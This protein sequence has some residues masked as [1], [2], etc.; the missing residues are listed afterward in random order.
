MKQSFWKKL[1][2]GVIIGISAGLLVWLLSEVVFKTFFFRIE[3]QTYDWRMRRAVT[4]PENPIDEIVIVDVDERSV[5][6]L[7]SYY[8]WPRERWT[9]LINFL[10][11]AGVSMIGLDF[12]FDPDLRHTPEENKFQQAM[13]NAEMVC[14]ALYLSQAD[15]D[16][17]RPVMAREPS[18][19]EYQRFIYQVPKSLYEILIPEERIEPEDANFLNAGLTAGYVNLFPDPDGVLRRIPVFMRF[20]ENVYAAFSARLP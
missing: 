13:H 11:G 9:K 5:Q 2:A 1:L 20:N 12:I 8:H 4:P 18:D 6:K 15:P 16:N 10:A 14:N 7:G 3:A 17:F 19:L